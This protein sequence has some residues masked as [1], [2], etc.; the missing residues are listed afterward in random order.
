MVSEPLLIYYVLVQLIEVKEVFI[1]KFVK[2][3]HITINGIHPI[4]LKYTY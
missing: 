3:G 2:Y 4:D 1:M